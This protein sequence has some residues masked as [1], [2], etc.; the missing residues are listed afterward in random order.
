MFGLSLHHEKYP[1]SI[2]ARTILQKTKWI[3]MDMIS[4]VMFP[5]AHTLA[6]TGPPE[7]F[8]FSL[9][10]F[11]PTQAVSQKRLEPIE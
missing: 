8:R 5:I 7:P 10:Q 1:V 4:A 6:E 9:C 2:I 11:I 3:N